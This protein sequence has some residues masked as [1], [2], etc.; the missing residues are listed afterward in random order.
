[1]STRKSL[2]ALAAGGSLIAAAG[3][4]A[5]AAANPA[6]AAL[7]EAPEASL[8]VGVAMQDAARAS[9]ERAISNVQGSFEWNQ[10]ALASNA[11]LSKILYRPSAFLCTDPAVGIASDGANRAERDTSAI[12]VIAV[13]G[14]VEHEFAA[15]VEDF[16]EKAPIAK[17]MGCTCGGNPADGRASANA[18][19]SGFRL[20]ALLDEAEPHEDANTITF[21][22]RDGFRVS[23]PL[24]YVTQRYSIIVTAINGEDASSAVGCSNQ[25]WLGST[26]ARSFARDIVSIEITH[27]EHPPSAPG[28]QESANLPN[29]GVLSGSSER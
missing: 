11:E 24:S 23:L 10:D 25:L 6:S 2:I 29:V 27:E 28:A 19:V 16:E 7:L 8:P 13:R 14:D 18:A 21:T 20:A 26:S 22:S 12:S 15:S 17:T 1:M 4:F 9:N 5:N 3:P